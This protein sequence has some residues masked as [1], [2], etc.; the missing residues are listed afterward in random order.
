MGIG[1]GDVPALIAR[2]SHA[3]RRSAKLSSPRLLLKADHGASLDGSAPSARCE[4]GPSST[5]RGGSSNFEVD[6]K[7]SL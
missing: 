7:G 1:A 4:R 5:A 3:A 2:Y 6:M